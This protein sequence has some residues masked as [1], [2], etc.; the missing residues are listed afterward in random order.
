M[1][2]FDRTRVLHIMKA[3][4]GSILFPA[5]WREVACG[6]RNRSTWLCARHWPILRIWRLVG[7]WLMRETKWLRNDTKR[8]YFDWIEF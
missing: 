8:R 4:R 5:K 2:K 6:L 7:T 1:M 3:S